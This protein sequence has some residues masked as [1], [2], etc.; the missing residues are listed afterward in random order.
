MRK[1]AAAIRPGG[2]AAF[3]P[4]GVTV[5]LNCKEFVFSNTEMLLIIDVTSTTTGGAGEQK[6][7]YILWICFQQGLLMIGWRPSKKRQNNHALLF[8]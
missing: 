2:A 7:I 4:G 3:R 5:W 8:F 6:E 1:T